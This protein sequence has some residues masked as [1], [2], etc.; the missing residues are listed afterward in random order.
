MCSVGICS[1]CGMHR[2]V[3]GVVCVHME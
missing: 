1:V 3:T 2:V